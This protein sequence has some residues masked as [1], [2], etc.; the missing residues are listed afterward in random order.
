MLMILNIAT[1]NN[2]D[3][4]DMVSNVL[5]VKKKTMFFSHRCSTLELQRV[6]HSIYRILVLESVGP[7][8]C[9]LKVS[10]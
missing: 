8:N 9:L 4:V 7:L 2:T 5:L 1:V 10:W 3:Q 6:T